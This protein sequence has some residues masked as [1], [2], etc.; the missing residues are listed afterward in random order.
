MSTGAHPVRYSRPRVVQR[1][2]GASSGL[3]PGIASG[4][5]RPRAVSHDTTVPSPAPGGVPGVC[6]TSVSN[7][8]VFL[9]SLEL[10]E[11][12]IASICRRNR[13]APAESDDFRS[14]ARIKLIENDYEAL[15][16]F[17]GRSSLRTY[18]TVVLQRVFLDYRVRQWGKWRPSMEARRSG[19]VAIRLEQLMTRD[20]LTFDEAQEVL[21]TTHGV[22]ASRDELAAIA[23]RLPARVNRRMAGEDAMAHVPDVSPGPESVL[24]RGE[25]RQTAERARA[26]L[27]R[28][29]L[30][31]EP[32]DRLIVAL[33]FEQGLGVVE[34]ARA[35][36]MEAKPLYGRMEQIL[37]QLRRALEREGV[38]ALAAELL[39][40][41][42]SDFAEPVRLTGSGNSAPR[43]STR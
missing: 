42:W 18:L 4:I 35:L 9:D 20:G 13:L 32:Q 22:T 29:V 5:I 43:P 39:D 19:P 16:R 37:T 17:A 30:A 23:E 28:A 3:R 24:A 21:R 31:L 34:I 7:D 26:A 14:I 8:R 40:E 36:A 11:A 41:P 33:R 2:T 27:E 10:I 1:R 25:L 6:R 15:R 12:V 38:A